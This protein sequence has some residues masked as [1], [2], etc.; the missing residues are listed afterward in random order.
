MKSKRIL[1]LLIRLF[2]FKGF[3]CLHCCGYSGSSKCFWCSTETIKQDVKE[4]LPIIACAQDFN[5]VWW[6]QMCKVLPSKCMGASMEERRETRVRRHGQVEWNWYLGCVAFDI[7]ACTHPWKFHHV[8]V[9]S[10]EFSLR[11]SCIREKK[12]LLEMLCWQ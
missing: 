10:F 11:K 8:F 2:G 1:H 12:I 4:R 9:F 5:R 7:E 3:I 6:W